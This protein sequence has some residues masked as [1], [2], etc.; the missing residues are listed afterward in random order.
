MRKT[1]ISGNDSLVFMSDH[2]PV[3]AVKLDESGLARLFGELEARIMEAVWALEHATVHDMC[4][5]LGE[6]CNYKT[7]MTVANRLVDKGVLKRRR[8][9]RAFVYDPVASREQFLE[10]VSRHT[11]A[12]LMKD[13]GVAAIAGFVGAVDEIA[14]EQLAALRQLI[15]EKMFSS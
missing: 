14:P 2:T 5:Y 8:Q 3:Q 1:Q 11:V 15:D 9:G 13:F 7:I 10:N 6:S 4:R 12:G